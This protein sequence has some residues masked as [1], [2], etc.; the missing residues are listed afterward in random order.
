MVL[1]MYDKLPADKQERAL[2]TAPADIRE[3]A[4][5][6]KVA[7]Q[8]DAARQMLTE[9]RAKPVTSSVADQWPTFIDGALSLL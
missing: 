7:G 2:R 5:K 4:E 9:A 8:S 1:N 6:A 3:S